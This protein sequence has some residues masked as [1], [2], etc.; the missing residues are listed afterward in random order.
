MMVVII[1]AA[2]KNVNDGIRDGCST[3]AVAAS[4]RA[5]EWIGNHMETLMDGALLLGG[6]LLENKR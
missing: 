4:K 5:I 1:H 2:P 3:T 6:I